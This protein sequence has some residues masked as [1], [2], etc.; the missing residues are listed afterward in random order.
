MRRN[1][2]GGAGT[3]RW[4]HR[5]AS[6]CISI[7]ASTEHERPFAHAVTVLCSARA[8]SSFNGEY[9]PMPPSGQVPPELRL[10]PFR[11]SKV[12]REGLLTRGQLRG[13]AWRRLFPDVYVGSD[14]DVDH[15]LRCVAALVH[16]GRPGV[17]GIAVSGLSAATC[18][19]IELL[20]PDA[21]VELTVPPTHRLESRPGELRVTRSTLTD[22]E[23]AS[24]GMVTLTSP[25]RTAFDTIRWSDRIDGIV[26]LD[27]MLQRRIVSV[28]SLAEYA[29]TVP[30]R[31]GSRTFRDAIM[32]SDARSE[33]PMETRTRL[34]LLDGGLPRPVAQ[35]VVRDADGRFIARLDLAY[36][37]HRVGIEYEGDHHRERGAFR[38]DIARL[39]ALLAVDWIIVRVTAD[40]I[41]RYPDQLL[42]L[43]AD[44]LHRRSP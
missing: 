36:P 19:G 39:N 33:S 43:I 2:T 7:G 41:Y 29:M 38:R 22:H 10:F 12:V 16:A 13:P 1:P 6:L 34:V 9:D 15:R 24:F 20:A 44:L 5:R 8:R 40:D 3:A 4:P 14:L 37:A 11:G 21:P 30:T 17:S 31:P 25:E 27:A 23:I 32:G 42:R 18:W 26:A 35:Y 28:R